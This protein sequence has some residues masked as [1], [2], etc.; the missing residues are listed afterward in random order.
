MLPPT[1]IL[2]HDVPWSA[3]FVS[4]AGA[5]VF[6]NFVAVAVHHY[7]AVDCFVLVFY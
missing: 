7:I 6:L 4:L 5:V 1:M 2:S 3:D